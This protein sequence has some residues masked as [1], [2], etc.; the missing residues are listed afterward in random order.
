MDCII[1]RYGELALKGKNRGIFERR[2]VENMRDCLKRNGIDGVIKKGEGRVFVFTK[3]KK[4]IPALRRVFGLVSLSPA[5]VA[6]ADKE[7]IRSAVAEYVSSLKLDKGSSFRIT[8]TRSDKTL[9]FSSRELNTFVGSFIEEE[10]KLEVNLTSPD[11]EIGIEVR[12]SAFIFHETVRCFGGLPLGTGGKV[13]CIVENHNALLASWLMMRRGVVV[14]PL[15]LK[16]VDVSLLKD[17]DYG[18]SLVVE[19][20]FSIDDVDS[21]VKKH[22]CDAVIVADTIE[23]LDKERHKS[24]GSVILY[25]LIAYDGEEIEALSVR[26]R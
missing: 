22:G 17:Y 6:D 9:P 15:I 24:I 26:I 1:C 8:S 14:S 5:V 23:S 3:D 20:I 21:M 10:F 12:G 19:N 25:P 7:K 2:L 18:F 16:K 4:A 13:V 11:F